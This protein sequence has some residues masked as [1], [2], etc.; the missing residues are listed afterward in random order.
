VIA[1][2]VDADACPVKDE[3]YRVAT[4][5]QL[6]VAVV[7]NAPLHVPAGFGAQLVVVGG[8]L[9][10][11]DDWIVENVRP[12]DV[13]V[14]ADIPLAARCLA[15]GA[16]ALGPDGRPFSEDSIGDALAARQLHAD[17]REQGLIGGGPRPLGDK[18]RARFLTRLD[19]LVQQAMRSGPGSR[20]RGREES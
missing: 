13:V 6:P 12:G 9:D 1:I 7:A 8:A 14:T 10:A 19:Q 2:F 5:Y 3:V 11:A 17:L 18:D 4:R 15:A 16:R 20:L